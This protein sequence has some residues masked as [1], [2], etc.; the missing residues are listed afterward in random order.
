VLRHVTGADRYVY[1][2]QNVLTVVGGYAA[3]ITSVQLDLD[4]IIG[5][6]KAIPVDDIV[7]DTKTRVKVT[8][9]NCGPL[10]YHVNCQWEVRG[11]DGSVVYNGSYNH[12]ATD[13]ASPCEYTEFFPLNKNITLHDTGNY[14][15]EIWIRDL[16]TSSLLIHQGPTRLCTVYKEA[17]LEAGKII[18]KTLE[19]SGVSPN[20]AIPVA[21]DVAQGSRAK[22][23]VYARNTGEVNYHA[24]CKWEVRSPAGS[25][26]KAYDGTSNEW[27]SPGEEVHF[28]EVFE[29]FTLNGTGDYTVEIELIS[30]ET[31]E[32]LDG[33]QGKLCTVTEVVVPPECTI[34]A[35][36]P[37][38]YVCVGGVCVPGTPEECTL[39]A[40]K[41]E[42]GDLYECV[43]G[44]EYNYWGLIEENSPEC[45]EGK[46]PWAWIALGV[47]GVLLLTTG[48]KK[49]APKPAAKGK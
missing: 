17:E 16:E 3:E 32:L 39:G 29:T 37:P 27:I 30:G 9:H 22:V 43:S 36:C 26:A 33:W 12:T 21:K 14:T 1:S 4:G 19:I 8:T 47:G 35:D 15:I 6:W 46:I 48:K 44:P 42:R 40:R 45:A 31:G 38:G 20:P 13:L 5:E 24:R 25:L 41:C 18:A 49:P 28:F 23:H 7:Q 11:P 2:P 10:P 34:D